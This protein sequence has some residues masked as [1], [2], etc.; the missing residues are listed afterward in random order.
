MP[1]PPIKPIAGI[2]GQ[3]DQ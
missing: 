1:L 2:P 3:F